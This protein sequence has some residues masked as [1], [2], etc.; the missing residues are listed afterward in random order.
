MNNDGTP[1]DKHKGTPN[2]NKAARK[3]L[4]ENNWADKPKDNQ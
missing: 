4:K 1:H 2:P 3:V